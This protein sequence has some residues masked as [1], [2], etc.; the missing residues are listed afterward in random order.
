MP[1]YVIARVQI[2]DAEKYREY[3]KVTPDV[4]AQYG[5]RFVARGGEV[6]TLEGPEETHRIVILEFPSMDAAKEWYHS[7][8]Y[9]EARKLRLACATGTLI[10]VDG[11]C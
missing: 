4:I 9:Q 10:A 8:E 6:A 5:G 2:A 1:A 3:T 11:C 7:P